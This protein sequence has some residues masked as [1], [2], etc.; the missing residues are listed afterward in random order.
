MARLR[1]EGLEELQAK[2]RDNVTMGDVKRVVRTNGAKLQDKIQDN[3][4]FTRGYATGQTKRSVILDITDGG[5]SAETGPTTEY[6][7]YLEHGTR[8][9]EAQP[10]VKPALDE[11]APKFKSDMQKLVR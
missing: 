4:D 6:A 9:M 2:L 3:A 10:F 1:I 5:F 7:Q 11:I 8:F